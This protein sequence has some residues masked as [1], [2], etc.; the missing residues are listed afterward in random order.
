MVKAEKAA[1]KT[2]G[3]QAK[4]GKGAKSS[5]MAKSAALPN[6]GDALSPDLRRDVPT[7]QAVVVLAMHRSGSSAITRVLNLL[8]CDTAKTLMGP[9]EHNQSGYWESDVLRVFND[10]LLAS[11]GSDWRDWQAFNPGWYQTPRLEENLER[12]LELLK[13]EFGSSKFFVFK[14]PRITR[15]VPFWRALFA[16]A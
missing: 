2:K 10:K 12:G 15:I 7:R 3:P 8:G 1:G 14:D 13:A 16:R 6:K 5:A 4:S 9:N 11:G